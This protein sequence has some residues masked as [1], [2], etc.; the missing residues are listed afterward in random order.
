MLCFGFCICTIEY[1]TTDCKHR[2]TDF[3]GK[4]D[5]LSDH[6]LLDSF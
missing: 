1:P 2:V 3:E 4:I 6:V 5:V